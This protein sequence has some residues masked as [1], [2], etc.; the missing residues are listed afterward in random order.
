AISGPVRGFS[1]E[2]VP[3]STDVSNASST[4]EDPLAFTED[5]GSSYLASLP[6]FNEFPSNTGLDTS[7]PVGRT[8]NQA[9][10]SF[11][12]NTE[13]SAAVSDNIDN[14]G[15]ENDGASKND[16]GFS[17]WTGAS[18]SQQ[19]FS[20][21]LMRLDSEP[22][23]LQ[24]STASETN[25]LVARNRVSL[26]PETNFCPPTTNSFSQLPDL[27][28][29]SCVNAVNEELHDRMFVHTLDFEHFPNIPVGL[30]PADQDC[31][32][33]NGG[34]LPTS[35][36]HLHPSHSAADPMAAVTVRPDHIRQPAELPSPSLWTPNSIDRTFSQCCPYRRPGSAPVCASHANGLSDKETDSGH[37]NVDTGQD[38]DD[39]GD[40]TPSNHTLKRP[41]RLRRLRHPS[42]QSTGAPPEHEDYLFMR[43]RELVSS[44]TTLYRP[45]N[46]LRLR[47]R[48]PPELHLPTSSS[49]PFDNLAIQPPLARRYPVEFFAQSDSYGPFSL[50]LI[51]KSRFSGDLPAG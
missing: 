32:Q 21:T 25:N 44:P 2:Q 43:S 20:P 24:N 9:R 4:L 47:R 39:E 50:E 17:S 38:G 30:H 3:T 11:T 48:H 49:C 27:S 14:Y 45:Q 18:D 16:S 7:P 19:K 41:P 22:R 42:H 13:P 15:Q 35:T 51:V 26:I 28:G 36:N 6:Y 1:E 29:L 23:A 40:V 8:T 5:L 12:A 31:L 46:S 37:D 33:R 34:D 10:F